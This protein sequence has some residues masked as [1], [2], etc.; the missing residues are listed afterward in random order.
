MS[1]RPRPP[2]SST[3]KG[4]KMQPTF[5]RLTPP[6]VARPAAATDVIS[7][8]AGL[9]RGPLTLEAINMDGQDEQDEMI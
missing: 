6:P 1:S 7:V 2:D 4:P 3:F 5:R 8:G 9:V